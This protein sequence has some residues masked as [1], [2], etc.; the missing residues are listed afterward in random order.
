MG[1]LQKKDFNQK[2]VLNLSTSAPQLEAEFFLTLL[3]WMRTAACDDI[4]SLLQPSAS[5]SS[6]CLSL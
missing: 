6:L 1:E 5:G 2:Y 4:D 3:F